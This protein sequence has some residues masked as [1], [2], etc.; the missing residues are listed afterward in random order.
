M[1]ALGTT[2]APDYLLVEQLANSHPEIREELNQIELTLERIG[3]SQ[4][5]EPPPTLET[6]IMATIEYMERLKHGEPPATAPRLSPSS[7]IQDFSEWLNRPDFQL[8]VDFYGASAHIIAST[9][10]STTA[11][12]WLG[13]GAPPE[14]HTTEIE[15]FLVVEGTCRITIGETPFDLGPGAY[16][17]IPLHVSHF[18][19]VTSSCPCKLILQRTAA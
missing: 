10:A 13:L 12:V 4:A 9:P 15:S 6:F 18:V 16:L 8:S 19:Q 1:Y 2:S 3:Q 7:R 17:S 14:V 5:I 11:I